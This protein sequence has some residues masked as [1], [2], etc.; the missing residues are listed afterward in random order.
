MMVGRRILILIAI[1]R[2][3]NAYHLRELVF[4]KKNLNNAGQME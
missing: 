2:F 3:C 4:E 1:M